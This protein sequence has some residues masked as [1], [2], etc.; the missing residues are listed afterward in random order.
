[1][2]DETPAQDQDPTT[3]GFN[4]ETLIQVPPPTAA[5][6]GR[7]GGPPRLLIARQD[8][9]RLTLGMFAESFA[10]FPVTFTYAAGGEAPEGKAD[11]LEVTG[12]ANFSARLVV[13]RDTHLPVLLLWQAPAPG[14]PQAVEHR[15]YYG[16]FKRVDGFTVPF[17][18]RHAVAGE[19][20]DETTFD[21]FR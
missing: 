20:V 21:R 1:R 9:A 17:R 5:P 8:F 19:T 3:V 2:T 18:I 11:I 13:Q 12:P 14:R 6:A 10:A 15:M 16:E 7:G 4:G